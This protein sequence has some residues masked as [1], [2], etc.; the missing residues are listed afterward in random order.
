MQQEIYLGQN[1]SE[2][3]YTE[4]MTKAIS[5]LL[6]SAVEEKVTI[7]AQSLKEVNDRNTQYLNQ[8]SVM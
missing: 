3:S 2:G 4:S 1:G 8:C 6:E 7:T 5:E